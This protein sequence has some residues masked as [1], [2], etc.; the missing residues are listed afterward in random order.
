MAVG[1]EELE[2]GVNETAVTPP[3]FGRRNAALVLCWVGQRVVG[4]D[5]PRLQ[6][7][8]I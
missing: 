5:S 8:E 2:E 7:K 1:W 6:R 3:G 4:C